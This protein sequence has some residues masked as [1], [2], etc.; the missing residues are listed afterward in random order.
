[1]QKS[2]RLLIREAWERADA[3]RPGTKNWFTRKTKDLVK[4]HEAV[5][6]ELDRL[7]GEPKA[8]IPGAGEDTSLLGALLKSLTTGDLALTLCSQE[9]P[10]MKELRDWL[11]S[12]L[13]MPEAVEGL[14][15]EQ[16]RVLMTLATALDARKMV[17]L[18]TFCGYASLAMALATAAD[19]RVICCE[20]DATYARHA[21]DW[22]RKAGCTDKMEMNEIGA[23]ELMQRMLDNGE[24][25]TVDMIFC[26]VGDR[27][28]YG[29]CHELAMDLL[30]VG[31]VVVYYETLWP[32]NQVLQHSYYPSLRE[33]NAQLAAD[34]R[35]LAS[36]VPL[37]YGLTI[38]Y[39]A[40]DLPGP[41]L[42]AA[43]AKSASGDEA[44]LRELLE[45]RR[46]E[47]Q[48]E[49]DAMKA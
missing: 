42:A 19:S 15:E 1:V 28:L 7:K 49:I 11:L 8:G 43:R 40:M 46:S 34:P 3:W 27:G 33:F 35:V 47:V 10:V 30:H 9:P 48:A 36:L 44:E 17:D 5:L 39:K 45:R 38:A 6:P 12:D 16:G 2:D 22:W 14:P 25:G 4:L 23:E 21:R 20:P 29:R 13:T 31:G 18:G 24:A 41:A 32:A 37:S 26:D